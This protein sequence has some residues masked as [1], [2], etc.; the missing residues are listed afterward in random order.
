MK[1]VISQISIC[2]FDRHGD[3]IDT[4]LQID[5][6]RSGNRCL[7]INRAR[8]YRHACHRW[9]HNQIVGLCIS[10]KGRCQCKSIDAQ[11]RQLVVRAAVQRRFDAGARRHV[12]IHRNRELKCCICQCRDL[13]KRQSFGS[14]RLHVRHVLVFIK[15]AAL[16]IKFL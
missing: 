7:G 12:F 8:C 14:C 11:R 9:I 1:D 16:H 15:V 4:A 3:L 5:R 13:R 2:R 6:S 10:V